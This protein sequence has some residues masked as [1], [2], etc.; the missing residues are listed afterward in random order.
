MT[1]VFDWNG[2]SG[3]PMNARSLIVQ[4][5]RFTPFEVLKFNIEMITR[6]VSGIH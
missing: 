1:C 2:F 4:A 5:T 6:E 3:V